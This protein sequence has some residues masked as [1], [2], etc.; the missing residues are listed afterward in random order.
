M[1]CKTKPEDMKL[2]KD[3]QGCGVLIR[4]REIRESLGS[5]IEIHYICAWNCQLKL[6]FR[7]MN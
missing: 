1:S 6:I 4:T 5:R 2:R 3:G 7:K